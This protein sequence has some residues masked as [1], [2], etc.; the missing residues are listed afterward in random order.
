MGDGRL[1]QSCSIAET[2]SLNLGPLYLLIEA[3][4][5]RLRF[6]RNH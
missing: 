1:A 3:I 5:S 4:S 2:L 6:P